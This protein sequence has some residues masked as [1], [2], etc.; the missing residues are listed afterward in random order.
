[1]YFSVFPVYFPFAANAAAT[2]LTVQDLKKIA[3]SSLNKVQNLALYWNL[4]GHL[5]P[6]VVYCYLVK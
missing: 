6:N 3:F 5:P 2:V 4:Y 1:M